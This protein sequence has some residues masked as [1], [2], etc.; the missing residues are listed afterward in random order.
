MHGGPHL[1]AESHHNVLAR[2][3]AGKLASWQAGKLA[4]QAGLL[5]RMSASAV[6]CRRQTH[7]L[8]HRHAHFGSFIVKVV[9]LAVGGVLHGGGVWCVRSCAGT[10]PAVQDVALKW[11]LE[12]QEGQK[13]GKESR[14]GLII[15]LC[16]ENQILFAG[17]SCCSSW[18]HGARAAVAR[19]LFKPENLPVQ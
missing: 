9:S 11:Y 10:A 17:L 12:I 19:S 15:Y 5:L 18:Q 4:W 1:G 16:L 14:T 3:Q 2:W 7:V 13:I 8:A 6:Q